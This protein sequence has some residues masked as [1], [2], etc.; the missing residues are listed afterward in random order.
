MPLKMKFSNDVLL[1]Y[2][3]KA[4]GPRAIVPPFASSTYRCLLSSKS[5]KKV[6]ILLLPRQFQGYIIKALSLNSAMAFL[7]S[8]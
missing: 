3:K 8:I 1:K 5:G 2:L 6:L 4:I 7:I